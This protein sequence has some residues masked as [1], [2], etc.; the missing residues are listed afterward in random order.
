MATA[1]ALA[2][3]ICSTVEARELRDLLALSKQLVSVEDPRSAIALARREG[4]LLVLAG[5]DDLRRAQQARAGRSLPML[6]AIVSTTDLDERDVEMLRDGADE[7]LRWPQSEAT[8]LVRLRSLRGRWRRLR[9]LER[10]RGHRQLLDETAAELDHGRELREALHDALL[11]VEEQT[12]ANRSLLVVARDPEDTC[13]LLGASD[14]SAVLG[15]VTPDAAFH[16]LRPLYESRQQILLDDVLLAP[17]VSCYGGA[18]GFDDRGLV[19]LQPLVFESVVFGALELHFSAG[20]HVAGSTLSLVREMSALLAPRIRASET[21]RSLREQTQRRGISSVAVQRRRAVLQKYKEFFERASDGIIVLDEERTLLHLNPMGE[22]ITGYAAHGLA[23]RPLFDIVAE[24]DREMLAEQLDAANAQGGRIFDVRLITTSG[25]PIVVSVSTSGS[26]SDE[27]LLVLSFRDVTEARALS[28]ELR[29]TKEFLERLID[30]TVDAIVAADIEGRVL[31]FNQGAER[32]FGYEVKDVIGQMTLGDFFP[33]GVAE[34]LMQQLRGDGDGGVG[35]LEMVRKEVVA[36]EGELVPVRVSASIIYE[37]DAEVG[38][39]SII[40]DLRERLH[41][42]RRLVQAQE[43]LVDAEKQALIAELAGTTAHELNQP[44]TSV[45]GY[46]ELLMRRIP[47]DDANRRAAEMILQECQRLAD[48]VR[49]IGKIT[50][51]ETKSY[52]GGARIL[53][54]DKSSDS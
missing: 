44:L 42:E 8:L 47:E 16:E 51:Y 25:D 23:G 37:N 54:L 52:V 5:A 13:Y 22:Q 36:E 17:R 11:G 7:V 35:R 15:L 10:H 18:A 32:I 14:D 30:S 26:L 31:L 24:R 19:L 1:E 12:E 38:T 3:V 4:P 2:I 20:A 40:S 53:D 49:K 43:R 33:E 41:M 29:Q 28:E 34:T 48:I 9:E 46:A 21:Y 27:E 50:R 45:M 39:V 6:G